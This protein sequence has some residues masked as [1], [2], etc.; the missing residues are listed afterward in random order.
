MINENRVRILGLNH[1]LVELENTWSIITSYGL[2][3]TEANDF[4]DMQDI[5]NER[6][7][8]IVELDRLDPKRN[9]ISF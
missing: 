1:R 4:K 6:Q 9:E 7:E 2:S 8:I 3:R 5:F